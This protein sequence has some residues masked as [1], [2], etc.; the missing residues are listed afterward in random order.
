MQQRSSPG[1][2]SNRLRKWATLLVI[3]AVAGAAVTVALCS[4]AAWDLSI[5]AEQPGGVIGRGPSF[6]EPTLLGWYRRVIPRWAAA[7]W[8]YDQER[9]VLL[10]SSEGGSSDR[11]ESSREG[12]L[13]AAPMGYF[14]TEN[15]LVRFEVGEG[16][17]DRVI[18]TTVGVSAPTGGELDSNA[19]VGVHDWLSMELAREVDDPATFE[20]RHPYLAWLGSQ[21]V[22]TR[23]RSV[24][25]PALWSEHAPQSDMTVRR[26]SP[27]SIQ[28]LEPDSQLWR[29]TGSSLFSRE[30]VETRLYGWPL[31]CMSVQGVRLHRWS[32]PDLDRDDQIL[33]SQDV[34]QTDAIIDFKHHSNWSFDADQPPATGLPWKP[35]W[36]PFLAN[37]L[38]LGAPV[39]L[40]AT[41]LTRV[42]GWAGRRIRGSGNKCPNCGYP[43][44][45]IAHDSV[46]PECGM[47]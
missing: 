41:G 8:A 10:E 19:A 9:F 15:V 35:M 43:R 16:F 34:H 21:A 42:L 38:I 11:T 6:D 45:G 36:L 27:A 32:V 4:I 1:L 23:M 12:G 13:P 24:G 47:K 39:V 22:G 30:V 31:R 33:L 26:V 40:V 3:H 17:Y 7:Q 29:M 25:N 2:S 18:R 5:P 46:C 14:I 44:S 28:P 20:L 37:S